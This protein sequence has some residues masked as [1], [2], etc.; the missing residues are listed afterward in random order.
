MRTESEVRARLEEVRLSLQDTTRSIGQGNLAG[1]DISGIA[2]LVAL[3]RSLEWV[4]GET[5]HLPYDASPHL[6]PLDE[7]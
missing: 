1:L 7:V 4:L 5:D 2:T 3:V 6:R